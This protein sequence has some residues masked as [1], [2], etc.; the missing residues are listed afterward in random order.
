MEG[1]YQS[2]EQRDGY[3]P[4]IHSAL[5]KQL[6]AI[7][8]ASESKLVKASSVEPQ[9]FFAALGDNDSSCSCSSS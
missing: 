4:E 2:R 6:T 1:T 5:F 8:P 7:R 3:Q 9:S